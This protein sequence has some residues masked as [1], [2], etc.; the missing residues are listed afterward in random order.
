M[1]S[2]LRSQA[3]AIFQAA[4]KAAAPAEAVRR[5]VR[6]TRGTLIAGH[7]RYPLAKFRNIYI[8]GAGKASVEMARTIERLLGARISAGWINTKYGH[9]APYGQAAPL[10]RIEVNECGHPL[11][12]ARGEDGAR[13]I[14]EIA[15]EATADDLVIC[16]ISGGA[17]AL[18]PLPAPPVTLKDIRETTQLLLDCGANIHEV[19]CARKHISAI[20]GGQLARL[21]YPA[22]VLALILSDVIGDD[23]DVIGSGPTVPDSSTSSSAKTVFEKYAIWQ[24]APLSVRQRIA[25]G[26]G[27]TPKPGDRVFDRVN[28]VVVGSNRL[29]VDAASKKARA[30]GFRTIVL[31]ASVQGEA[32]EIARVHA[33]IAREI[34]TAG[35]PVRLPACVISGGETTVTIRGQGKGGRNQE[36]ALAAAIDIASFE[37]V[38]ILSAGT[39]GSDGPTDAAGAIA[40]GSSVARAMSKGLDPQGC[41]RDNDSYRFFDALGDLFKTGPTGTNVAD[42]Q[43]ILAR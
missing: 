18:L 38:L 5:A 1:P 12:D 41:L 10:R 31:T 40:D 9:A 30:L 13:R 3:L 43:I 2:S 37:N 20:Q 17:S 15:D 24:R 35:R 29:A 34:L 21:A 33:A 42:I 8:I 7:K 22:T 27:E 23:L 11:P 14:A 28:N 16:L 36:F 26:A 4:L 19:N 6:L 39:D 32:R 25:S